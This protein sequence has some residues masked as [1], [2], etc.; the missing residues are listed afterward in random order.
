MQSFLQVNKKLLI[1][2]LG[3]HQIE[4]SQRWF[5][6]LAI[7]SISERLKQISNIFIVVETKLPN[8]L[9]IN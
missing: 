7:L 3:M 9:N 1:F 5:I 2:S 4:I 8:S 6:D